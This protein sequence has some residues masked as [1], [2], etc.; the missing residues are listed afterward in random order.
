[1]GARGLG[2]ADHNRDALACRIDASPPQ[3]AVFRCLNHHTPCVRA[4]YMLHV[5]ARKANIIKN[6]HTR[7]R[8]FA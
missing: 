7:A 3:V 8:V 5:H 6:N 1:M 2:S 4:L